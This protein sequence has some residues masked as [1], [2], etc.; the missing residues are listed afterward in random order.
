[1]WQRRGHGS[2]RISILAHAWLKFHSRWSVQPP[3]HAPQVPAL[4][5]RVAVPLKPAEHVA[6]HTLPA[7]TLELH[8][9]GTT[10]FGGAVG[11]AP[12]QTA[13]WGAPT[14]AAVASSLPS[15]AAAESLAGSQHDGLSR[16]GCVAHPSC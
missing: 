11:I 6:A 10:T 2:R 13:G 1:M 7:T 15:R 12:L 8:E 4:Q 3:L 5:A 16:R 9:A 14:W